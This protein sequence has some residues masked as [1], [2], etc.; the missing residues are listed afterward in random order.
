LDAG[1]RRQADEE[2][3]TI[4]DVNMEEAQSEEL[5]TQEERIQPQKNNATQ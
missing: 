1:L 2:F 4:R 3:Q 5:M